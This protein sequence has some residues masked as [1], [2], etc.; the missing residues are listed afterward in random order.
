MRAYDLAVPNGRYRVRLLVS[1][2]SPTS[3]RRVF[4][5]RAEGALVVDDF[6]TL[7]GGRHAFDATTLEFVVPVTDGNLDL[8]FAASSNAP[9]VAAIEVLDQPVA[10]LVA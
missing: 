7:A 9:T 1:E 10:G 8:D 2:I 4:D 3:G 6:D 5:V